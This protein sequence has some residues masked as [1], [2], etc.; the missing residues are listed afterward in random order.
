MKKKI[1]ADTKTFHYYN[2]NPLGKI[3]SD[4]AIRAFSLA[5][6]KEW[7]AIYDKL[8]EIGRREKQTP[9]NTE[10]LK[11]YL[12]A[13][14]WIKQAQPKKSNGKKYTGEEWCKKLT[15]ENFPYSS[16]IANIGSHH[17]VCIKKVNNSFMIHDTWNSSVYCIGNYWIKP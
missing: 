15:K 13:E 16:I 4:C 17:V 10:T 14:G 1:P 9:N 5:M 2:A 8:C 7:E 6:N 11:A 12:N 3:T